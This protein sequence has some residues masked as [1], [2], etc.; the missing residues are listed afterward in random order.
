LTIWDW[1]HGTLRLAIPQATIEIGVPA[2]QDASSV[3]LPKLMRMPFEDQPDYWRFPDG[4]EPEPRPSPK[5][6][7]LLP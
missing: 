7:L 2:Y 5:S 6:D 1:L 3:A 4:R